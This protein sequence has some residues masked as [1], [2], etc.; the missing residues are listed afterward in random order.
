MLLIHLLNHYK[1]RSLFFHFFSFN[2]GHIGFETSLLY[3]VLSIFVASS[4]IFSSLNDVTSLTNSLINKKIIV[5]L[6]MVFMIYIFAF[7]AS[8]CCKYYCIIFIVFAILTCL[9]YP[10]V[11]RKASI[12]FSG[13]PSFEQ[14]NACCC[15]DLC[16]I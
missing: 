8:S 12:R 16:S 9:E 3:V 1:F 15:S 7:S 11:T 4:W 2:V 10:L 6:M 13:W 14:Y 5:Y